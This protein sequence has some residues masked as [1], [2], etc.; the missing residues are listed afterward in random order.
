MEFNGK[1]YQPWKTIQKAQGDWLEF[2]EIDNKETRMSTEETA[3]LRQNTQQLGPEYGVVKLRIG[4]T[5]EMDKSSLGIGISLTEGDQGPKR[6]WAL[7]E[8]SSGSQLVDEAVAL[9]L[10]MCKAT[11]L[12]HRN[13]QFQVQN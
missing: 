10:A 4:T 13:M 11:N 5:R 9:K 8:S 12:Q 7:R 1:K 6:G 3:A 2:G